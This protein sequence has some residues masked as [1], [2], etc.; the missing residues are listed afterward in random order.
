VRDPLIT[1]AL[2]GQP[3][4]GVGATSLGWRRPFWGTSE[5]VSGSI[6]DGGR[7]DEQNPML[8]ESLGEARARYA[9]SCQGEV[10][11]EEFPL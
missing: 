11:V 8:H 5:Y 9:S 7:Q 10:D 3:S 2:E 1:L 4:M 6:G